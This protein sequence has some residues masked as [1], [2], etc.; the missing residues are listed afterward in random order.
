MSEYKRGLFSLGGRSTER[1]SAVNMLCSLSHRERWKSLV[2]FVS[3]GL[4]KLEYVELG[5]E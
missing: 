1:H 2:A 5:V 4:I 3:W